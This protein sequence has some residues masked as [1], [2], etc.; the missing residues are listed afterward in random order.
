LVDAQ[1]LSLLLSFFSLLHLSNF[2]VSDYVDEQDNDFDIEDIEVERLSTTLN[3]YPQFDSKGAVGSVHT[4]S[5]RL[6]VTESDIPVNQAAGFTKYGLPMTKRVISSSRTKMEICG[7]QA[8]LPIYKSNTLTEQRKRVEQ[9]AHLPL[10]IH[11]LLTSPQGSFDQDKTKVTQELIE[12]FER[13]ESMLRTIRNELMNTGK[14][15]VRFEFFVTSTLTNKTCDITLPIPSPWDLLSTIDHN[16]FKSHSSNHLL[17][18]QIPLQNFVKDLIIAETANESLLVKQM[19]PGIRTTLVFCMEKCVEAVN[20]MGFRG[21][22]IQLIWGELSHDHYKRDYFILPA[23][24]LEASPAHRYALHKPPIAIQSFDVPLEETA[25]LEEAE[26]E[27]AEEEEVL[28]EGSDGKWIKRDETWFCLGHP[29]SDVNSPPS[30]CRC[31]HIQRDNQ[32]TK[33]YCGGSLPRWRPLYTA[34]TGYHHAL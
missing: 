16:V 34:P 29:E 14:N 4:S 24:C 25:D 2:Y 26:V 30:Y 21:R 33:T 11:R 32:T 1:F 17:P 15:T 5:V 19:P 22:V 7:G 6:R 27:Q 18:Y 8:Y 31:D 13:L 20:I 10:L 3:M 23:T 9:L 28:E 12:K